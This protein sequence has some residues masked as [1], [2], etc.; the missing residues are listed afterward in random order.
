MPNEQ[1]TQ[2]ELDALKKEVFEKHQATVTAAFEWSRAL[3]IGD[4]RTEAFEI[5]N[6][7]RL[8][9]RRP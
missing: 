8:S 2:A 9:T 1:K 5:Y 6:N 7:I 3:P 4:E